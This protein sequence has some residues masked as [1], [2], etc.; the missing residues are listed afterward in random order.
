VRRNAIYRL[1]NVTS[2]EP[3]LKFSKTAL[4]GVLVIEPLTVFEDFRGQYVELDNAPVYKAAGI[5]YDFIQDDISVSRKDVLRGIHGDRKTAK[6]VSCLHGAFY[7][8]VVNNIPDSPQYRQW[9]SFTLSD[10][11]RS[12]V[13]I[14]PGFGNGHA[15]LTEIA[16]FHYKQTTTYDRSSQFTLRWDDPKLKIWWPIRGPIIS[17]RDGALPDA[18]TLQT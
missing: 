4:D 18:D 7:L 14:P 1:A 17:Q 11:N 5:D 9:A 8:V 15:V 10:R 3:I 12:Q 2:P 13:L 16:M 6:L